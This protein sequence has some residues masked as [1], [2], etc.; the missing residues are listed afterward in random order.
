M[1]SVL[2]TPITQSNAAKLREEIE[3]EKLATDK[4]TLAAMSRELRLQ[5]ERDTERRLI[6]KLTKEGKVSLESAGLANIKTRTYTAEDSTRRTLLNIVSAVVLSVVTLMFLHYYASNPTL[7]MICCFLYIVLYCA[8]VIYV[9]NKVEDSFP[10]KTLS[11]VAKWSSILSLVLCVLLAISTTKKALFAPAKANDAK[12]IVD[13]SGAQMY[14]PG[15]QN[16][17]M[18]GNKKKGQKFINQ[19]PNN[20]GYNPGYNQ[21][22]NQG[23]NN[24]GPN[25]QG[26]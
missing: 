17:Q 6:D 9:V 26:Q 19:G 11:I 2:V 1:S 22:Y 16:N 15:G 21:G 8:F 20:Q 18:R 10:D 24:Q 3:A 4:R 25:N 7:V 5:E 12:K 23:P 13:N 14:P